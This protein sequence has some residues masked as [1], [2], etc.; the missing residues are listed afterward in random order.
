MAG[1]PLTT[2]VSEWLEAEL[3]EEF[4]ERGEGPSEGLRR[5]IEEWWVHKHLPAIE[6]REGVTGPRPAIRGGPEVW[7]V[8]MVA[9]ELGDTL[10][11]PVAHFD[12]VSREDLDQAL[13]CY[14]LFPEGIDHHLEENARI[15]RLFR[16]EE[17]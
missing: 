12:R 2:R 4:S 9:R 7:E 3:K 11:P 10:E 8:V 5:V 17:A 14:R 13:A 15:E 16:T 6:W 1:A